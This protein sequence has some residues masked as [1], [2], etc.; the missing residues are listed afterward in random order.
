MLQSEAK[1]NIYKYVVF[2]VLSIFF[3]IMIPES[4][5][6]TTGWCRSIALFLFVLFI[7]QVLSFR[8]VLGKQSHVLPIIFLLILYIFNFPQIVL[9]GFNIDPSDETN[10]AKMLVN[11]SMIT[12]SVHVAI[13]SIVGLFLGMTIFYI[14]RN[15]D[16]ITRDI[17]VV[18]EYSTVAILTIFIL[19]LIADIIA[20]VV[21]VVLYGYSTDIVE[22]IPYMNIV[23]FFSLLLPSAVILS[24]TK[25]SYS[26]VSKRNILLLFVLYK[27][28]CIMGGYRGFALINI[29][30]VLFSYYKLCSPFKIKSKHIIIGV[31]LLVLGS[32]LMVGVRESRHEGVDIKMVVDAMFDFEHNAVLNLLYEFGGSIN[33]VNVVLS[34]I[35]EN[36]SKGLLDSFL[37]I[38]PGTS[39]L[40]LSSAENSMDSELGLRFLGGNL[41]AD[42]LYG[43]GRNAMLISSFILGII[44]AFFFEMFEKALEKRDPFILAY[45][46]PIIVDLIFCSRSS[47][48]KM[49]REIVWFFLLIFFLTA[50]FPRKKYKVKGTVNTI[51]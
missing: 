8:W 21:T 41:I 12:T 33:V 48:T 26:L 10:P 43:Y 30:L 28:L 19:G 36:S 47:I 2:V 11:S 15:K 23:R 46:F 45:T 32:G 29:L 51:A 16:F 14:V 9:N 27:F 49:P 37:N 24:F 34:E 3:V 20:N 6:A 13:T 5:S 25:H 42:L 39:S 17:S 1:R 40:G 38:I 35:G 50:I 7:F 4:T 22:G 18:K 31:I 44:F